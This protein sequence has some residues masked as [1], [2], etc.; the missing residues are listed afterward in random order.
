[1]QLLSGLPEAAVVLLSRLEESR[2]QRQR[3]Q[4]WT[5]MRTYCSLLGACER[6]DGDGSLADGNQS[7]DINSVA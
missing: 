7:R 4:R 6:P 2:S 5:V 3:A 1:M